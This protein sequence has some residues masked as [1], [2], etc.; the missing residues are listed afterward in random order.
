MVDRHNLT[1]A[2]ILPMAE[3]GKIR[4]ESRRKIAA[5]K[6]TSPRRGRAFRDVLF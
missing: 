3:Y 5:G 6:Q 1:A 2:D 4:A